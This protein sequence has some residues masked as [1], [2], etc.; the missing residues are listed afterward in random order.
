M[1]IKTVDSHPQEIIDL[2]AAATGDLF[3]GPNVVCVRPS[4]LDRCSRIKFSLNSPRP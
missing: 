1:S 2:V 3:N 4:H